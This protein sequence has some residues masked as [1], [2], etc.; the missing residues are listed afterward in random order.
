MLFEAS[1]IRS[2]YAASKHGVLGQ[3]RTDAISY[4]ADGIRVNAV[5]PGFIE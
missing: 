4:G 3:T 1:L 5:C 2:Q